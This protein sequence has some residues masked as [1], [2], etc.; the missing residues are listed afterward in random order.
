MYPQ[1]RLV[2][3]HVH[4]LLLDG[5][6]RVRLVLEPVAIVV[7]NVL[8]VKPAV[9]LEEVE[10]CEEERNQTPPHSL[11]LRSKGQSLR[12]CLLQEDVLCYPFAHE[13]GEFGGDV[14][15]VPQTAQVVEV[16]VGQVVGRVEA[17]SIGGDVVV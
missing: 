15:T 7:G 1:E 3:V 14:E 10:D 12:V 16:D 9:R 2:V 17:E 5:V 4:D 11:V 13:E 8:K 6:K